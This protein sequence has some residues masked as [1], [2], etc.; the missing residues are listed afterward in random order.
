MSIEVVFGDDPFFIAFHRERHHAAAA[1]GVHPQIIAEIISIRDIMNAGHGATPADQRDGFV[2]R[3]FDIDVAMP[4]FRTGIF[5]AIHPA[6]EAGFISNL[7]FLYQPLAIDG[8]PFII[9][10]SLEILGRKRSLIV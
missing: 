6:A 8:L 1:F 2:F 10:R 4:G 7:A 3:T 5:S 9:I